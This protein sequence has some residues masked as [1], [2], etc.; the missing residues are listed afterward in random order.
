MALCTWG[1]QAIGLEKRNNGYNKTFMKHA[2]LFLMLLLGISLHAQ[3]VM[4]I[5]E[6]NVSV[7]DGVV[8][9]TYS[10]QENVIMAL[11]SSPI[12]CA[13]KKYDLDGV[14]LDSIL[15]WPKSE[16]V[17]DFEMFPGPNGQ[18]LVYY[19]ETRV[20]GDT[21][22]FHKVTIGDDM[23]PV[24]EDYDWF[25][26]DFPGP[27]TFTSS[28]EVQVTVN[29]DGGAFFTYC[30]VQDSIRMVKFDANGS[31]LAE[32]TIDCR[33]NGIPFYGCI[34]TADSLGIHIA[35]W[36]SDTTQFLVLGC[37]TFDSILNLV[38]RVDDLDAVS[39]P[40]ICNYRAYYR[41]NPKSGRTYSISSNNDPINGQ[42]IVMSMFD[43]DMNQLKYTWGII[44]PHHPD[45]A[46]LEHTID[47]DLEN[48]VYMAGNM[49]VMT[50]PYIVCLD[51][52]LNKLGE[53]HFVHPNRSQSPICVLALPE[54]GCLVSCIG[55]NTS[56]G[57]TEYCVYKVTLSDLLDV[58]EAHSHGFAVA[59]AYP[60][61][62][63]DEL[64]LQYSPDVTPTQ[65]ELYDL[66]GRLVRTQKNGMERLEMNGLPAGT[67]TMRVT[68]KGG[69]VFS[70]KVVK[71]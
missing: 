63:Q 21:A 58:E 66:Q 53:I 2:F 12:G 3:D 19:V 64:H 44:N 27:D 24:F 26:L 6:F 7:D 40:I 16:G 35:K 51:E 54:G 37:Y 8:L 50:N 5:E 9:M 57:K 13:L 39:K 22:T 56:I 41:F 25:G 46:G 29:K 33:N 52:D 14:L 17:V 71:E 60:N 65:I 18:T 45:L 49:E 15:L 67:Y 42:D 4:E 11:T 38:H 61:P 55:Y 30:T 70:D 20:D 69:K 43:E 10:Q 32:R 68:L 28:K 47:F 48:R 36:R 59:T 31:V 34:P 1:A 62:V 23:T